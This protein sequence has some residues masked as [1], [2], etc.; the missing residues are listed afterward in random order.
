MWRLSAKHRSLDGNELMT[1]VHQPDRTQGLV[2]ECSTLSL[3]VHEPDTL[4]VVKRLLQP[5]DVGFVTTLECVSRI[6]DDRCAFHYRF[7]IE[8]SVRSRDDRAV[9]SIV[10]RLPF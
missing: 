2:V 7:I 9:D 8:T 1:C 10:E 4:I 3:Q 5:K 6:D